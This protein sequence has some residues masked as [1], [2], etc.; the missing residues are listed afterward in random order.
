[1]TFPPRIGPCELG[2]LGNW[3]TVRCPR[4]LAPLVRLAGGEWEPGSRQWLVERRRM[5]P[6]VRRLKRAT[7]PLFRQAGLSL[8]ES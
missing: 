3:I 5:G 6:L 1:M 7:D 4:E 8:D 2:T